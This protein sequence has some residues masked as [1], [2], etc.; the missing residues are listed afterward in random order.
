MW[1]VCLM[2]IWHFYLEL[3][4]LKCSDF[5]Q[6]E[7]TGLPG[8]PIKAELS[9]IQYNTIQYNTIQYNTIGNMHSGKDI[10][11]KLSWLR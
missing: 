5:Y 10:A 3:R 6:E 11:V 9:Y 4:V 2:Y 8:V 1:T 7:F